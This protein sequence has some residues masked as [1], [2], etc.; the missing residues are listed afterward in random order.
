M[1]D[2]DSGNFVL[3]TM[4]VW[5][6]SGHFAT[7]VHALSALQIIIGLYFLT[8]IPPGS[9]TILTTGIYL[10]LALLVYYNLNVRS[11]LCIADYHS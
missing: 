8:N 6:H 10:M 11:A 2:L 5:F 4:Q 7:C 9:K 3:E 1:L